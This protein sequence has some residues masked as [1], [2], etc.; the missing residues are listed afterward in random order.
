MVRGQSGAGRARTDRRH[1]FDLTPPG[2]S[3]YRSLAIETRGSVYNQH[4]RKVNDVVFRVTESAR[5][6]ARESLP[7]QKPSFMDVSEGPEWTRRPAHFY[8]D[9]DWAFI[10]GIWAKELR[11]GAAPPP[12]GRRRSRLVDRGDRWQHLGG[13][14]RHFPAA[15]E[16]LGV[17]SVSSRQRRAT[18]WIAGL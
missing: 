10:E 18:A 17:I 6:Y 12:L 14:S 7:P 1:V 2:G 3:T 11:R 13:G 15:L 8:T 9:E 5:Q 16:A 4:G